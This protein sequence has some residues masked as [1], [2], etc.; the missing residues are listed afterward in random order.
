[1]DQKHPT[2]G[3]GISTPFAQ[4]VNDRGGFNYGQ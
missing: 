2:C 1:M 3:S 4:H